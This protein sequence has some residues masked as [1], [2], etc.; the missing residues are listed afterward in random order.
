VAATNGSDRLVAD[1][2]CGS[3][4]AQG[5]VAYFASDG[6][7][8][9]GGELALARTLVCRTLRPTADAARR[10]DRDVDRFCASGVMTR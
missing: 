1:P 2:E 9:L 8:L 10:D 5:A 6:R 3:K 7:F 4:V